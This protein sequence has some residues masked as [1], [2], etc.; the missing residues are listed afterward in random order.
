MH[1]FPT[2]SNCDQGKPE[3]AFQWAFVALPFEGSTPFMIQPE[4]R[5]EWSQLFWD[6]GFRHFPELQTRKV[7]P[8]IRG[9][10]HTL[11]PS[12]TVVDVNDPDPEEF[13]GPDMSAYTVHEQAIVAEQLRHLQNQGDRP[14][15]DETASVVADQFNPADHSV[16][17]VLGYLHHATD[18]ERRRVIAAEMTGKRRDGIMRRY[19]GI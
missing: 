14:D 7:R 19:K 4:A 2:L 17:Y 16:S 3:D 1:R 18:F 12:V 5:K 15:V 8:P 9:G 11:N 10:T 6:L 13:K